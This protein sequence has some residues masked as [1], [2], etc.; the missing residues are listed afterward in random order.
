MLRIFISYLWGIS[1]YFFSFIITMYGW[2]SQL[3][4]CFI[5]HHP[6]G[7]WRGTPVQP[8]KSG[9]LG[10]PR[11]LYWCM[12][13]Q[14]QSFL[15]VCL[16]LICCV[17]P[18]YVLLKVFCLSRLPLSAC[19]ARESRLFLS[20]SCV[21]LFL[22]VSGLQAFLPRVLRSEKG[23]QE[24]QSQGEIWRCYSVAFGARGSGYEPLEVG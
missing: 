3:P 5:P 2:K 13:H 21:Y 11:G 14:A 17:W 10:Y 18:E 16:F 1:V 7:V 6:I 19:L 4:F 20:F 23:R 9:I 22:G 24:G 12:W 8:G 15:F